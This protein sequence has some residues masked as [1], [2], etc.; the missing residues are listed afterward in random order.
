[1]RLSFSDIENQVARELLTDLLFE[2]TSSSPGYMVYGMDVGKEAEAMATELG[3]SEGMGGKVMKLV[4]LNQVIKLVLSCT[5][6]LVKQ[7]QLQ[8][9]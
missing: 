1:M 5:L 6:K 8:K 9:K 7:T 4:D 2:R 3:S